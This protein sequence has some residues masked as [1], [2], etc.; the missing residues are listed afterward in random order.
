M[1]E[2]S[3][4]SS[5][6]GH[7]VEA[8]RTLTVP[9]KLDRQLLL[10]QVIS[11][12]QS[13]Q[14]FEYPT[15]DEVE[16]AQ[17]ARIVDVLSGQETAHL[18]EGGFIT[19]AM[20]RP[21][22]DGSEPK[23]E[24]FGLTDSEAAQRIIQTIIDERG[25]DLEPILVLPVVFS[26]EMVEEFYKGEPKANQEKVAPIRDPNRERFQNRWEEFV[27]LMLS[28][29]STVVIFYSPDALA[30][31]RWRKVLGRNWRVK[32]NPP[33]TIRYRFA[34]ADTHNNIGHGS[35]SPGSVQRELG[36]IVDHLRSKL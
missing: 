35:D 27:D 26:S 31:E 23:S 29:P 3:N 8:L 18:A 7:L 21:S 32:Q 15:F 1:V 16:Q 33:D 6:V 5:E 13:N 20:I 9:A 12:K 30:V 14:D 4:V 25:E 34:K 19:L 17:L 28:G 24:L 11:S 10:E 22:A 2:A 36:I